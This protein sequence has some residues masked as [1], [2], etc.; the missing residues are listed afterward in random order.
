MNLRKPPEAVKK[1]L[2]ADMRGRGGVSKKFYSGTFLFYLPTMKNL[3][4]RCYLESLVILTFQMTAIVKLWR[5][6]C[7][8]VS[9]K[10]SH[11]LTEAWEI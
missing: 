1:L 5:Y 8:T 11:L 10:F 4:H 9:A 3:N 7:P 6:F 2:N